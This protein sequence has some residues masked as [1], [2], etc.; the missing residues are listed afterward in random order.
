MPIYDILALFNLEKFTMT[1]TLILQ[2]LI[3]DAVPFRVHNVKIDKLICECDLPMMFLSHYDSL[4]DDIK[5]ERPLGDFLQY[6]TQKMT[7]EQANSL[8][9]LAPNTIKYAT[10]IKIT[11]TTVFV[12][13]ELPLALH[14]QFTNTSKDFQTHYGSDVQALIGIEA[15]NFAFAGNVNV[16]HKNTAKTLI[17]VDLSDNEHPITPNDGYTRLPNTHALATT[18]LLN[19]AK[20][21]SPQLFTD[22]THVIA[23]KAT[24][25]FEHGQS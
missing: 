14:L 21:K 11:G 24:E 23:D 18:Q 17:S 6:S 20:V 2:E 12:W 16:L 9:S 25:C 4:P 1:D 15:S 7:A 22:L 8:L 10:H 19:I 13:D 5:T 3:T